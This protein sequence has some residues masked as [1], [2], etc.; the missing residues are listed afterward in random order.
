M[1]IKG[2]LYI[3]FIIVNIIIVV[4]SMYS[5]QQINNIR[6]QYDEVINKGVPELELIGDMN[7]RIASQG[8]YIRAHFLG[9]ESAKGNLENT[10]NLLADGLDE[11]AQ[12]NNMPEIQE[13]VNDDEGVKSAI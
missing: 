3:S 13:K 1:K 7:F 8:A 10:Q 9:T 4:V 11:L 5:M 12:L 2:K 6:S